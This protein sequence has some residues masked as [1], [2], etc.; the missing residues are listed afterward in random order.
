MATIDNAKV[1]IGEIQTSLKTLNGYD[2]EMSL[3]LNVKAVQ[4]KQLLEL[5]SRIKLA[6]VLLKHRALELYFRKHFGVFEKNLKKASLVRNF[7]L[8][9]NLKFFRVLIFI[10]NKSA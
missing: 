1:Q 5:D 4:K 10:V 2:E 7:L 3:E 8:D 9:L 6:L